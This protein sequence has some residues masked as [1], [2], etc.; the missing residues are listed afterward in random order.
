MLVMMIGLS[1]RVC[2]CFFFGRCPP[3]TSSIPYCS[4][5]FMVLLLSLVCHLCFVFASSLLPCHC[6]SLSLLVPFLLMLS[7]CAVVMR[8][9]ACACASAGVTRPRLSLD[10][11]GLDFRFSLPHRKRLRLSPLQKRERASSCRTH[12]LPRFPLSPVL[13]FR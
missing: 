3:P 11:A 13:C 7:D 2:V 12:L 5:Y 8:L 4:I 9:R 10:G 1:S 6:L